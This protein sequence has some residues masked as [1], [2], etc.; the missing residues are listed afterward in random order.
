[1]VNLVSWELGNIGMNYIFK[2]ALP[3]KGLRSCRGYDVQGID[4]VR[5]AGVLYG[6]NLGQCSG[7]TQ[8]R[9]NS[10]SLHQIACVKEING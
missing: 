3:I 2:E 9:S 5:G 8:Q 7:E 4:N 1:M 10:I 6:C